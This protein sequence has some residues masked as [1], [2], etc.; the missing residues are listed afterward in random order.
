MVII[1][2]DKKQLFPTYN[3]YLFRMLQSEFQTFTTGS[4]QPQLPIKDLN[5]MRILLPPLPEQRAIAGVLGSLDDKIDLLRRQNKTLETMAEALFRQWFIEEEGSSA[6]IRDIVDF[7]PPRNLA[8][9]SSAPYLEMANVN[10]D[11]SLVA[12]WYEREFSS[13]TKFMN[14]DTLLARITPCLE[15][16]KAC[17]VSFLSQDQIGWGS[18]EFIVMRPKLKFHPLLSYA[19]VKNREFRDFAEGCLE[20]SSGR[21]RVNVDHLSNFS[22]S[23]PADRIISDF[24]AAMH[25]VEPKLSTNGK[26]IRTLIA[27]RDVLLPKLMS[28]EVRVDLG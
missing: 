9:G 23:L 4:A 15:N 18:T 24:N 26:Q 7:A 2:P 20:G 19:L 17:Y 16:G 14:G 13:G 22:I 5:E 21:Q 28:G 10:S 8:K 27:L 6:V 12:D 25:G 1:R 3:Y 11:S